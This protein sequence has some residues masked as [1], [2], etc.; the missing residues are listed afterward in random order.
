MTGARLHEWFAS[1]T[2]PS[3]V[4]ELNERVYREL[5]LSPQNDAWLGLVPP[6][7]YAGL[8]RGG[9]MGSDS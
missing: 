6:D 3:G 5:F 8:P 4:A 2:A 9:R 7:A 1:G